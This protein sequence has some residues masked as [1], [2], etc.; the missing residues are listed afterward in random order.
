MRWMRINRFAGSNQLSNAFR[1]IATARWCEYS[2]KSQIR[3]ETHRLSHGNWPKK[4]LKQEETAVFPT[5]Y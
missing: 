4:W 5:D 1:M 2:R 3:T